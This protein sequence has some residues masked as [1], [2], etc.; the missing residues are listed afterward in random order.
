MQWRN[1]R[2][3]RLTAMLILAP[4]ALEAG[5]AGQDFRTTAPEASPCRSWVQSNPFPQG[6]VEPVSLG[7]NTEIN[8]RA[9]LEQPQDIERG[10]ALAPADGARESRVLDSYES[11]P[12]SPFGAAG[13][14][15]PTLVLPS[16]GGAGK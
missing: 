1:L 10:R 4:A 5:C 6:N 8:L 2:F 3:P 13:S 7:C 15:A 16:P 11:G 9:T 14:A 12:R